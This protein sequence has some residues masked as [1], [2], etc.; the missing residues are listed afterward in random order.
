MKKNKSGL[1][2]GGKTQPEIR[3]GDVWKDNHGSVVTV[4]ECAINRVIYYRE[5]YSSPCIC[6]P[7]RLLRDFRLLTKAPPAAS[8]DLDRVMSVTGAERIRVVREIIQERGKQ[9]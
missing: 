2:S 5:D 9:K 4:S 6:S 8:S 7:E 3:P 1:S